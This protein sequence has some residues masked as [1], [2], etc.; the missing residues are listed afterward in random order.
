[1]PKLEIAVTSLDDLHNAVEGGAD[2]VE[3]SYDLSVGGLTPSMAM[4]KTAP[5][6]VK[7][8]VHMIIRP[9]A[10]DFIY[11]DDEMADILGDA[12]LYAAF[13]AASI[14]FGATH[15]DYLLNVTLIQQVAELIAPVPVTVHRALDSCA[16]PDDALREL[17]GIV[18]RILTSGPAPTAWEGR[19]TT[20][21]WVQ[22]FGKD[23]EFVLSGSIQLDQLAELA[24]DTQAPVFHIGSAARTNGVVDVAKVRQLREILDTV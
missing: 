18:P 21:R 11:T 14:V 2:S 15:A 23:F 12:Q 16:N 17:V 20:R 8:P 10:R 13:G 24:Q 5:Q 3:L 22:E 4:A 1:M 19:E 9:H 7:I 6:Q